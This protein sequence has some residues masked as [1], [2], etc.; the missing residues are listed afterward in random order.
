M[1]RDSRQRVRP[2]VSLVSLLS[3]AACITLSPDLAADAE[4]A[5]EDSGR[6]ERIRPPS[7][8][9]RKAPRPDAPLPPDP[10]PAPRHRGS[11]PEDTR[12]GDTSPVGEQPVENGAERAAERPAREAPVERRRRESIVLPHPGTY[13][14][15]GILRL[16]GKLE[17]LPVH[18]ESKR[19]NQVRVTIAPRVARR[20]MR[21]GELRV[22]LAAH[23]LF[24]HRWEHEEKGPILVASLSRTWQP[25]APEY[26]R[27]LHIARDR[28]R[29]CLPAIEKQV[30]DLNRKRPESARKVIAIPHPRSGKVFLWSPVESWLDDIEGTVRKLHEKKLVRR[31]KTRSYQGVHRTA[32][33]LIRAVQRD[34]HREERDLLYIRAVPWRNLI[35]WRAPGSLAAKVGELLA[36]HDRG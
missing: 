35:Y 9:A 2:G 25:P 34:L 11:E 19:V 30:E 23:S 31:D 1:R 10:K 6:V 17:G 36:K 3:L 22:L 32:S 5:R 8:E 27:T 33:R 24:L 29:L 28:W 21:I 14:A 12:P 16:A 13:R 18:V 4:R 20:P 15:P 26:R 7:R